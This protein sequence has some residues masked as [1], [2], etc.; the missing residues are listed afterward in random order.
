MN[1][2]TELALLHDRLLSLE[3]AQRRWRRLATAL[4]ALAALPLAAFALRQDPAQPAGKALQ[5]AKLELVNAKGEV[6]AHFAINEHGLP[7]LVLK[8]TKGRKRLLA[9]LDR[10]YEEPALFLRDEEEIN[11]L[12]VIVDVAGNPFVVLGEKGGKPRAQLSVSERG[13][14][15]LSFRHRDGNLNAGLG[16]D[17]DGKAWTIL[18]GKSSGDLPP[19]VPLPAVPVEG[20]GKDGGK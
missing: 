14:P 1:R 4:L 16:L 9:M 5:A 12:S 18:E 11:R 19:P 15:S 2:D 17:A 3:N 7:E 20:K 10:R 13:A 8:D 6:L